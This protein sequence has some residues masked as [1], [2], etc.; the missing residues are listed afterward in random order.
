MPS[1]SARN[2]PPSEPARLRR[3][4]LLPSLGTM[5]EW[6]DFSLYIYL[7]P[8]LARLFFPSEDQL[9]ALLATFAVFAVAYLARPIGAIVFGE[10]GDRFGRRKTLA[11]SALLMAVPMILIGALP[12][13]AS[14]GVA[15]P[16]ALIVLRV[17]MGFAVGGEYTG[18]L[19]YLVEVAKRERRGFVTSL[20][21][22]TAG[23]GALGA[24][25]LTTLL[26]GV[27]SR[28]ELDSWG[29]RVPFFV[30]AAIAFFALYARLRMH[31]TPAFKRLVARDG[32]VDH[33]SAAVLRHAPKAVFVAFSVSA[34]GSVSY[35]V[36][37]SYVPTY[38]TSIVDVAHSKALLASTLGS[39]LLLGIMALA[40]WGSDLAGR[41]PL[42]IGAAVALALGA[43][44]I[45]ALLS[46]GTTAA[47]FAGTLAF[48]LPIGVYQAAAAAAIPEQFET[49]YRFSGLAIGYNLAV[50]LFGGLAPLVATLLVKATGSDGAPSLLVIVVALGALLVIVGALSETARRPL[51]EAQ[52]GD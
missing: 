15:A 30:G 50:A 6:Y 47:V 32:V 46:G 24:V 19:T 38:L 23:I 18:V 39:A 33:P 51:R 4:V 7:S 29:W 8:I 10:L 5:L 44:P 25:G 20:A 11:L 37:I 45:F 49:A 14:I 41:R 28:D 40:G 22:I 1:A 17:A 21:P 52:R 27:L 31:E 16:I 36:G 26:V 35:F 48:V 34:L 2:L 3:D 9:D 12:T 43:A 42:L 13:E